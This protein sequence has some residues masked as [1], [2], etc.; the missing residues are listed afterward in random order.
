MQR[1]LK[2]VVLTVNRE[3]ILRY[4]DITGDHNPIHVDPAFAAT[5]AMGGV[6]A[7]GTLSLNLIW[8]ALAVT[9]GREALQGAA[10]DVRFVKPVR[11]GDT[12]QAGGR[13]TDAGAASFDVWV[14]NQ[15]GENVIEG[16]GR[17]RSPAGAQAARN[18]D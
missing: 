10:L 6:I 8:Q 9:C 16:T 17:L 7:H 15:K 18:R 5:T 14:R 4:A 13:A 2:P 1:E 12:V 11:V 3:A